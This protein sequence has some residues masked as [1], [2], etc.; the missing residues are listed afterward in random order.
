MKQK[1]LYPFGYGLSYTTFEISDASV[2]GS[3]DE[4]VICEATIANTGNLTGAQT[5]QVYVKA[6]L[7]SG[8]NA[9]LRG[10]RKIRLQPGESAKVSISLAK[11]AFGVYNEEGR[12]VLLPG[13][14]EIYV[15]MSQPDERSVALLKTAPELFTI[16]RDGAECEI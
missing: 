14:Y 2:K 4:G 6:P 9:Q 7:E 13:A 8:P 3:I 16:R 10:L 5:V 11:D 12:K 15:G 1:A